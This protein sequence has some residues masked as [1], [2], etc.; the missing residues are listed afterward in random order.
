MDFWLTPRM[1][2]G[3]EE[4]I[5]ELGEGSRY[6]QWIVMGYGMVGLGVLSQLGSV[7]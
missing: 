4:R 7:H 3:K 6:G 5:C 2:L 1:T